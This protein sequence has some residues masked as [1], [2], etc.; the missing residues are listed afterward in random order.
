MNHLPCFTHENRFTRVLSGLQIYR[1]ME[2]RPSDVFVVSFPKAGTTW[3]QEVTYLI[4]TELDF[5]KSR[6]QK[7]DTRFPFLEFYCSE[8]V[9]FSVFSKTFELYFAYNV[10]YNA[11]FLHRNQR[12]YIELHI[13]RCY[14]PKKKKKKFKPCQ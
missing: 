7:L 8:T 6:S 11:S 10:M 5:E 13:F 4:K 14:P 12:S 2:T 9:N 3:T 1:Q